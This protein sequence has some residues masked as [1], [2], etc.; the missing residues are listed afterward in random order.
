MCPS[1]IE[2]G[3]C[4]TKKENLL[5]GYEERT[6]LMY[7]GYKLVSMGGYCSNMESWKSRVDPV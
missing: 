5:K 2:V 4:S 1:L 7:R 6:S 3:S